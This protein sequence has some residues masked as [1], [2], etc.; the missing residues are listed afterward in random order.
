MRILSGNYKSFK[1]SKLDRTNIQGSCGFI[2]HIAMAPVRP[3]H[4]KDRKARIEKENAD[5]RLKR[6]M[7]GM[8]FYTEVFL[9]LTVA[10]VCIYVS[11]ISP[12][13]ALEERRWSTAIL[14]IVFG[15]FVSEGR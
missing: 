7:L 12:S 5:A 11:L 2:C 6:R 10:L 3:E 14:I 13:A 4:D 1:E 15:G 8:L 9:R